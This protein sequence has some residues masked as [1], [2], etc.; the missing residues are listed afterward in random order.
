MR[1][2]A[3]VLIFFSWA[4]ISIITPTLVKWSAQSKED[5]I[6][7]KYNGGVETRKMLAMHTHLSGPRMPPQEAVEQGKLT[8]DAPAPAPASTAQFV[9]QFYQ[10]SDGN[11][12]Q[13]HEETREYDN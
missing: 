4:F 13:T 5:M 3:Y 11:T 12:N 2:R 6:T 8:Q 10:I 1:R 9:G 7:G